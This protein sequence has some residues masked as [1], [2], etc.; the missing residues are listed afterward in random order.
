MR[1]R[2]AESAI[3]PAASVTAS[4]ATSFLTVSSSPRRCYDKPRGGEH[5]QID[6][7]RVFRA[8]GRRPGADR[9]HRH[10]ASGLVLEFGGPGDGEGAGREG[11]AAR[12]GAGAS[13]HGLRGG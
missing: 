5:V 12:R 3:A 13:E 2:S 8:G 6:R 10:H 1:N 9:R 4:T 11:E 7:R